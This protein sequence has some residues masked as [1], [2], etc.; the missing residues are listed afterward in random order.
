MRLYFCIWFL[1]STE[2]HDL[3]IIFD[4]LLSNNT[5]V[6]LHTMLTLKDS[7]YTIQNEHSLLKEN[8]SYNIPRCITSYNS[9]L[10]SRSRVNTSEF[11]Q[12]ISI[13]WETRDRYDFNSIYSSNLFKKKTIKN[14]YISLLLL[15]N[16][17][18]YI[19]IPWESFGTDVLLMIVKYDD[20]G[21]NKLSVLNLY[22][23]CNKYEEFKDLF[24]SLAKKR[25]GRVVK[26]VW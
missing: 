20:E 17:L 2:K 22:K 12:K 3:D 6:G 18:R 9:L 10:C 5:W 7:N 15:I 23:N 4:S 16:F 24:D 8:S 25:D 13:K 11:S 26:K 19:N 14:H 1:Y 21:S